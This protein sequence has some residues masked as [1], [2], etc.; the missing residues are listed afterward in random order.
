MVRFDRNGR[1]YELLPDWCIYDDKGAK[2]LCNVKD[3]EVLE[4]GSFY[5]VPRTN[6]TPF[7]DYDN[8]EFDIDPDTQV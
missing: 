4:S 7:A 2:L 8:A 3:F 6:I 1:M 5:I